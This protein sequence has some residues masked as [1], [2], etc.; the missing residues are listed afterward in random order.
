MPHTSHCTGHVHIH[1]LYDFQMKSNV[2]RIPRTGLINAEHFILLIIYIDIDPNNCG[3]PIEMN[4]FD[5]LSLASIEFQKLNK[6][7]KAS[8]RTSEKVQVEEDGVHAEA[9]SWL[10]LDRSDTTIMKSRLDGYVHSH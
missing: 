3:K 2:W 6:E 4:T 7:L 8:A 10:L 1:Y 5:K 9:L